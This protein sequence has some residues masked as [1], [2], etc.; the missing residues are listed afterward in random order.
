MSRLWKMIRLKQCMF[1][2][3][4]KKWK[5]HLFETYVFNCFRSV[6]IYI[7]KTCFKALSYTF[8]F[9][10]N[11]NIFK[12]CFKK[13]DFHFVHSFYIHTLFQKNTI[14]LKF[15]KLSFLFFLFNS[16]NFRIVY[17]RCVSS[18]R[19]PLVFPKRSTI[20]RTNWGD[21]PS[22]SGDRP[23]SLLNPPA[24]PRLPVVAL[25]GSSISLL[26]LQYALISLIIVLLCRP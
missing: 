14:H 3:R 2:N 13:C 24:V 16:F 5:L 6:Y 4:M 22:G 23:C 19:F 7:F 18:L 26:A 9:K 25:L 12:K 20:F 11:E 17:P 10:P 1:I 15:I 21:R 8:V